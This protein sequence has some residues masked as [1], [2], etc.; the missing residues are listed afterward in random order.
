MNAATAIEWQIS[1]ELVDYPTAIA[2][3]ETRVAAIHAGTAP[4][5]I[6]LLQHPPLYTAGTSARDEDLLAH[7]LPVYPTGRGGQYTYHGPG[8]RV[9]Y[10]MLDLKRRNPDLRDY[11]ARLEEWGIRALG[12]FNLRVERRCGRVGLWLPHHGQDAKIAAIGVRVRHWITFHGMAINVDPNLSAFQGIVPCGLNQFG[13]TSMVDQGLPV[14][15]DDLDV[16]LKRHF[17]EVFAQTPSAC[18]V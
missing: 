14:T 11:I 9:I 13:V 12:D 8:Q 3:M 7:D 16:A 17:E 1:D 18:G 5:L 2:A 6:W 10:V 4:E 15:M